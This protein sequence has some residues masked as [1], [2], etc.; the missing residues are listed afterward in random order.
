VDDLEQ[1]AEEQKVLGMKIV[2]GTRILL[3]VIR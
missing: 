1:L 3:R 2:R